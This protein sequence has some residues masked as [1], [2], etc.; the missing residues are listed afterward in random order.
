MKMNHN[1][2]DG[3]LSF[4][5]IEIKEILAHVLVHSEQDINTFF[6]KHGLT[7][8]LSRGKVFN[9]S[10]FISMTNTYVT[11]QEN[12]ERILLLNEFEINPD[13]EAE[14]ILSFDRPAMLLFRSYYKNLNHNLD[15][16]L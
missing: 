8:I 7:Y 2:L 11:I 14:I 6:I 4:L 15:K 9:E 10:Y 3:I 12:N 13:N 1:Y 5:P 16:N